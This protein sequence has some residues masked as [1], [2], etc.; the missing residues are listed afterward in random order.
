VTKADANYPIR[1]LD[2]MRVF[3]GNEITPPPAETGCKL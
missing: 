1:I 3:P 2:P